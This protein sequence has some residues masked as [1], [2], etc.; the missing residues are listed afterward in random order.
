MIIRFEFGSGR[1]FYELAHDKPHHHHVVCEKCGIVED[2]PAQ[3]SPQLT[4]MALRHARRFSSISRHSL[5]F[6][7]RC[8]ECT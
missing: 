5:E 8:V 6:Y 4:R 7:G 3:D 2:V 1:A